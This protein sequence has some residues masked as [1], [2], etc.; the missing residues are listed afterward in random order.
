MKHQLLEHANGTSA[1]DYFLRAGAPVPE[2]VNDPKGLAAVSA[3]NRLGAVTF[4][5]EGDSKRCR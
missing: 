1:F 4:A 3:A 5:S 2:A